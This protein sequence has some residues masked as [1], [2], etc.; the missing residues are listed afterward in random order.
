MKLILNFLLFS[1]IAIIVTASLA[2]G[3][4]APIIAGILSYICYKVVFEKA[5]SN[6]ELYDPIDYVDL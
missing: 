4:I 1:F 5:T 3:D 2:S 6:Q